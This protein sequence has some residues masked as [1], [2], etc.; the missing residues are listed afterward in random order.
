MTHIRAGVC[1]P[2]RVSPRKGIAQH[3]YADHRLVHSAKKNGMRSLN[4]GL[5]F[6]GCGLIAVTII[7]QVDP[8]LGVFA[9]PA[10][11]FFIAIGL[12]PFVPFG[13]LNRRAQNPL[14]LWICTLALAALSGFWI[15]GFGSVFWWNPAPDAQDGLALV[16][17]PAVMIAVAGPVAVGVWAIERYL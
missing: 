17:L 7:R 5:F 12:L 10:T 3:R 14:S 9:I 13:V 16:V 15:W 2:A 6:A 1:R 8:S 11:G 4:L